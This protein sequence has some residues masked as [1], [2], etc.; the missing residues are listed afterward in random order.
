MARLSALERLWW[1]SLTDRAARQPGFSLARTG[2]TPGRLEVAALSCCHGIDGEAL[3]M[4][5]VSLDSTPFH[6]RRPCTPN[7]QVYVVFRSSDPAAPASGDAEIDLQAIKQ[8]L[9]TRKE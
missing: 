5:P 4:P 6:G 1:A 2:P 9:E 7:T 3:F 8:L